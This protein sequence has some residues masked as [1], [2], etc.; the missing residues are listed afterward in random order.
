MTEHCFLLH[1]G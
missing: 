1:I